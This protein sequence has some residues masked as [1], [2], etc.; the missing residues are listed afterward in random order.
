LAAL[1]LIVSLDGLAALSR[2]NRLLRPY[3]ATI[4]GN[5]FRDLFDLCYEAGLFRHLDATYRFDPKRPGEGRCRLWGHGP[6]HPASETVRAAE[7][8]AARRRECEAR[9]SRTL[10]LRVW[11]RVTTPGYYGSPGEAMAKAIEAAAPGARAND[12]WDNLVAAPP[13]RVRAS[14]RHGV[15]SRARAGGRGRLAAEARPGSL[16]RAARDAFAWDALAATPPHHHNQNRK[17][18][19]SPEALQANLTVRAATTEEL[20]VVVE[21]EY[22]RIGLS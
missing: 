17:D 9:D 21:R 13:R 14:S 4:N 22:R 19:W 10:T 20:S 6:R 15:G 2:L 3:G 7:K 12:G 11:R 8:W 1:D 16:R 18:Y 5:K